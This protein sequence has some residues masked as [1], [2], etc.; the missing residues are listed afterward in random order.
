MVAEGFLVEVAALLHEHGRDKILPL[1]G[2]RQAVEF[3]CAH[4]DPTVE[5]FHAFLAAFQVGFSGDVVAAA[6]AAAAAYSLSASRGPRATT[7]S[8]RLPTSGG[9]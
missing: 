4:D 2:Y 8:A 1:V 7:P 9:R 3:L 5:D 6:T